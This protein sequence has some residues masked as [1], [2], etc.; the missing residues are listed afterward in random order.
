MGLCASSKEAQL[1]E[2]GFGSCI[3]YITCS[4][5]VR[6][7]FPKALNFTAKSLRGSSSFFPLDLFGDR[8]EKNDNG[9]NLELCRSFPFTIY[10]LNNWWFIRSRVFAKNTCSRLIKPN[11]FS[12]NKPSCA[13][14]VLCVL[15][16][17]DLV[18]SVY[19]SSSIF[20]MN[21]YWRAKHKLVISG[22]VTYAI[23]QRTQEH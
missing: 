11:T 19:T 7:Q 2:N 23:I 17:M 13:D 9:F 16:Q 1:G 18:P 12:L 8:G 14:L 10:N 6:Q 5:C 3:H 22:G 15:A 4:R 21:K 20:S